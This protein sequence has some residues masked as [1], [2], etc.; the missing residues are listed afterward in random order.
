MLAATIRHWLSNFRASVAPA[1]PAGFRPRLEILEDR[2][3]PANFNIAAGDTAGLI[4]AL[5]I[6][7]TNGE[8]DSINLAANSTYTL[9]AVNNATNGNNGLPV[10]N[11]DGAVTFNGNGSTITRDAAAPAFRIFNVVNGRL[12]M[13][14]I[15]LSNG[16]GAF[17]GAIRVSD[18]TTAGLDNLVLRNS[19]LTG[20]LAASDGGGLFVGAGGKAS[21]I[22]TTVSTNT[23][24]ANGGGVS[25]LD[26][27]GIVNIVNVTITRNVATTQNGGGLNVEGGNVNVNNTI[28][29]DNH[30]VSLAGAE[31]DLFRLPSTSGGSGTVNASNSLFGDTPTI[32]ANGTLNGA[33]FNNQFG[34]NP[35]LGPLQNNGGPTQTHALTT[36]ASPAVDAGS[37][38]LITSPD[39]V[40]DQRGASF[41]RIINST[42]DIG[43]YEYQPPAVFVG[44]LSNQN[45]APLGS[46][47]TFTAIVNGFAPNSNV[48]SGT[49]TYIIDGVAVADG[50]LVNGVSFFVVSGL[51]AGN[52]TVQIRYN[53]PPAVGSYGFATGVSG[54]LTQTIVPPPAPPP[55][56]NPLSPLGRRWRR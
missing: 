48:V 49:V 9:T 36:A 27:A 44:I 26:G 3:C 16:S 50:A 24:T 52:H 11:N 40:S 34:A 20:N 56:P 15:T 18:T 51:T 17:G 7:Q 54:V 31:S 6:A 19:L 55:P 42:V 33:Q 39:N 41:N 10:I 28:L 12:L 46:Q 47:V 37:N 53:P 13:R 2:E 1:R 32:G 21:L 43:A 5:A 8:A 29:A 30:L 38:A 25:V 45:P 35:Q 14:D 23:A 22:N 4:N